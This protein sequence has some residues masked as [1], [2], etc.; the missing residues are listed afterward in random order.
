MKICL[1][2]PYDIAQTGGVTN[3]IVNYAN[4]LKSL[5]NEVTILTTSSK[6]DYS[7]VGIAIINLG[8]P[9]PIKFEVQLQIFL[10]HGGHC[11]KSIF[12]LKKQI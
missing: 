1:V 9:V 3:H 11:L 12:S 2:S 10:F 6:P 8:K 5:G 4:E 7:L